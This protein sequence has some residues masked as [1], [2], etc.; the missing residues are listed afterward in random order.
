METEM[1]PSASKS[2]TATRQGEDLSD[3]RAKAVAERREKEARWLAENAEAIRLENAS[4]EK[5][6]LP[7]S[8]LR[9]F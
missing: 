3:Q 4:I 5:H 1:P 6:G 7:L 8:G 9:L 2:E